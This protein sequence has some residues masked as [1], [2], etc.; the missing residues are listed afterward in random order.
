M[1]NGSMDSNIGDQIGLQLKELLEVVCE[2]EYLYGY[3]LTDTIH[4][5]IKFIGDI[6]QIWLEIVIYVHNWP[7]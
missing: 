3:R 1:T 4:A 5:A 7:E 2:F 6:R